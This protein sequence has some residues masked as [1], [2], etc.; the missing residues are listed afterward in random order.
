M[1]ASQQSCLTSLGQNLH[2]Y[3]GVDTVLAAAALS[4]CWLHP[5]LRPAG[6]HAGCHQKS[7]I[8]TVMVK[9]V[10]FDIECVLTML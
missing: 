2:P 4:P 1:P 3:A 5:F 9:G 7:A 6:L 10:M 8:K